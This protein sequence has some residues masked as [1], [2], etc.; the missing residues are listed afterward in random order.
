LVTSITQIIIPVKW[1]GSTGL[2]GDKT[3]QGSSLQ[4]FLSLNNEEYRSAPPVITIDPTTATVKIIDTVTE[5]DTP[6]AG[7]KDWQ[8][9]PWSVKRPVWGFQ[10]SFLPKG[11][12][13][14]S[15]R[16]NSGRWNHGFLKH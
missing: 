8:M 4:C 10:V 9:G 7:I 13:V 11:M 3:Q 5:A 1:A 6:D 2:L 12:A 16:S 14:S 15:D